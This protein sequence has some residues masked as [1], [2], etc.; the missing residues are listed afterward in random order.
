LKIKKRGFLEIKIKEGKERIDFFVGDPIW[1]GFCTTTY[2]HE[3]P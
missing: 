2:G 3:W 1:T